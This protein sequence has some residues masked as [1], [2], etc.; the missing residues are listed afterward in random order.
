MSQLRC[1]MWV[2]LYQII[3]VGDLEGR[4]EAEPFSVPIWVCTSKQ[5]VEI[6]F[7][8]FGCWVAPAVFPF[9]CLRV[10]SPCGV[11]VGGSRRAPVRTSEVEAQLL[12]HLAVFWSPP[13]C[14]AKSTTLPKF[15]KHPNPYIRSYLLKH[16]KWLLCVKGRG[17]VCVPV[18]LSLTRKESPVF[19]SCKK[20]VSLLLFFQ[21]GPR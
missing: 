20:S 9:S 21:S 3:V 18:S 19:F 1:W 5:C 10:Q 17:C 14:P 11:G 7:C 6:R 15:C 16:L 12:C 8:L 4:R 2:T 13:G